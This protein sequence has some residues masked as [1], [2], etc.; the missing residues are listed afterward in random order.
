MLQINRVL[1]VFYFSTLTNCINGEYLIAGSELDEACSMS[2]H[3]MSSGLEDDQVEKIVVHKL[4][5]LNRKSKP[6]IKPSLGYAY[7]ALG[8]SGPVNQ[9]GTFNINFSNIIQAT[10]SLMNCFRQYDCLEVTEVCPLVY[11]PDQIDLD[12]QEQLD[13]LREQILMKKEIAHRCP[14]RSNNR[15]IDSVQK[16]N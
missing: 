4:L 15:L 2:A 7:L 16:D 6:G 3:L 8:G 1:I 14:F 12:D 11:F 9:T 10:I 5:Q 13:S